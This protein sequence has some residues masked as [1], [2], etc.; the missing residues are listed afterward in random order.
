MTQLSLTEKDLNAHPKCKG[1]LANKLH[2]LARPKVT[3]LIGALS[4]KIFSLAVFLSRKLCKQSFALGYTISELM[5]G[6]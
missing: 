6:G 3:F 1:A 5:A 2:K 4:A